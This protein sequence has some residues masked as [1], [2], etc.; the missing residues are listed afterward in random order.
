[1]KRQSQSCR[2]VRSG[3]RAGFSSFLGTSEFP[4]CGSGYNSQAQRYSSSNIVTEDMEQ[5]YA[6]NAQ[7]YIMCGYIGKA[8]LDGLKGFI[9]TGETG[10]AITSTHFQSAK[11]F[12]I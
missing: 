3:I 6:T 9:N 10:K 5:A 11:D 4:D 12:R 2:S 8:I 7:N 1:M